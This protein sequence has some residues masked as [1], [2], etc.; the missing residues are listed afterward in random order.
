MTALSAQTIRQFCSERKHPLTGEVRGSLIHPF[1]ERTVLNGKSYG[2]AA[3]GYDVRV[4]FDCGN[5]HKFTAPMGYRDGTYFP[6]HTF[7]LAATVE[8]FDMPHNV[9]GI[10]H[11]KSTWIRQGLTLGNTVIEPGWRGYLTLELIYHGE[12]ELLVCAGDP[13]AQIAFEFLDHPTDQ[14]YTG[15]Y[16]DQERGPQAARAET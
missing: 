3:A 14:P 1:H 8:H 13:I 2:L 11:D 15:K 12:G 4:E 6:G 9:R 7:C 10:V 5:I 16:Q